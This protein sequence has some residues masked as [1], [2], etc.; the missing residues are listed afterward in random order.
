MLW[1]PRLAGNFQH[2]RQKLQ[3]KALLNQFYNMIITTISNS[4]SRILSRIKRQNLIY[5]V[6]W[7]QLSRKLPA[8]KWIEHVQTWALLEC[9]NLSCHP[10][11]HFISW[12]DIVHCFIFEN[13]FMK[14]N[15]WNETTWLCVNCTLYFSTLVRPFLFYWP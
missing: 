6:F 2:I 5:N 9:A 15:K 3:L 10:S 1:A 13:Y 8:N 12:L 11:I 4:K 7:A 14:T